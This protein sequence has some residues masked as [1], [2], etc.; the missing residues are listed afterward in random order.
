VGSTTPNSGVFTTL[1]FG[2]AT[3]KALLNYTTNTARTLTVPSLGGN[4][5]FAFIDQNQTF[6]A[7][8]TFSNDITVNNLTIGIGNGGLSS[9]TALGNGALAS[10]TSGLNNTAVGETAL[11]SNTTAS[12][13]TAVGYQAGYSGTTAGSNTFL[14]YRAGYAVVTG[15]QSTFLGYNA[16]TATTGT[17]NLFIGASTGLNNTTGSY[18]TYVGRGISTAAG[19]LMTTGSKNTILGGFSG[20][21]GGLDI[22][23]ENNNIV[24]SDGDGTPRG[25]YRDG[26]SSWYLPPVYNTTSGLGANIVIQTD[27]QLQ[28]STSS[29][30]YKKNVQDAVHG[31]AE[32]LRLRA[33]T[34][35]SK[36][37]N[38]MQTYGGLIAEEVHDAGLT[39]FVQYAPDGTPDTLS[40]GNMVSLC[41]KAI[42][43][44]K[45]ELDSVKAELVTLQGN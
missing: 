30:K 29:L 37:E 28:R 4:R 27:G 9:N 25:Y 2:T 5:T 34:Y 15:D 12:N 39:E 42:Q 8:Q 36:N 22:R 10:S 20:N 26:V 6:T 7:I 21:Q 45:S 13:N 19:Y 38:E 40:Y 41:I 32:V 18:N 35:N 44:L 17:E 3:N 11:Y 31:L 1:S 43:E 16:G 24:L 23:I 33:V 14:G